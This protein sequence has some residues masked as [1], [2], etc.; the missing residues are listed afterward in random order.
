MRGCR[1]EA[2]QGLVRAHLDVRHAW[3]L[4]VR[5]HVFRA[6]GARPAFAQRPSM[7]GRLTDS[8]GS[9]DRGA[10]VTVVADSAEDL[11]SGG[12]QQCRGEAAGQPLR[13]VGCGPAALGDQEAVEVGVHEGPAQVGGVLPGDAGGEAVS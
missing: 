1:S 4:L 10:A 12:A 2:G 11:R 13:E 6:F 3:P 7:E 9:C 8:Q 5:F